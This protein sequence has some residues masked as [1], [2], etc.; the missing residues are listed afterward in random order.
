MHP[1]TVKHQTV[2]TTSGGDY[3]IVSPLLDDKEVPDDAK[4]KEHG[5]HGQEALD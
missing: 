3:D 2:A 1:L 5:A 4:T